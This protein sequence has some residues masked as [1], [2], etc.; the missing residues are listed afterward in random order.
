MEAYSRYLLEGQGRATA[1][2]EA[3][4]SLRAT[5]PHPF[6]TACENR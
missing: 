1:L 4:R 2:R 3:M 6:R 5:R